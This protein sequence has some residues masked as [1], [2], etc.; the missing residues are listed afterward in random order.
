MYHA[1][2]SLPRRGLVLPVNKMGA[3]LSSIERD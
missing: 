2:L 3:E 1:L